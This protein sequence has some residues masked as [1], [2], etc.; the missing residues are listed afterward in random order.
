M[1]FRMQFI[2]N[3]FLIFRA[4]CHKKDLFAFGVRELHSAMR[5][6]NYYKLKIETTFKNLSIPSA[7]FLLIKA[8]TVYNH[9]NCRPI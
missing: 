9:S 8:Y 1:E 5:E 3:F 2:P 6:L 7:I 4:I